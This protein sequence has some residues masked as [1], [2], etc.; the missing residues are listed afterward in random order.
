MPVL[1]PG[2]YAITILA[3]SGSA[4]ASPPGQTCN[5]STLHLEI[6]SETQTPN[7]AP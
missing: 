7:P 3:S 4:L 6:N 1:P 5:Y 2:R